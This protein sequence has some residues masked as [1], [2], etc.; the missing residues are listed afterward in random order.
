[1]II[2]NSQSADDDGDDDAAAVGCCC[3]TFNKSKL[4]YNKLIKI[5]YGKEFLSAGWSRL[6]QSLL[7]NW[8]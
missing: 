7:Y 8:K 4:H 2:L 1:M 3:A 5:V 6:V